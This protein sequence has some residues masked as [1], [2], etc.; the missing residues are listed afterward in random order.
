MIEDNPDHY[1]LIEDALSQ[2]KETQIIIR[3]EIT[4]QL[5]LY[6]LKNEFFDVCLCDLYL[7]DSTIDDSIK[8]LSSLQSKTPVVALSSLD[9]AEV[10]NELS[11]YTIKNCL[12]KNELTATQ[13]YNIC[14]KAI[15][16]KTN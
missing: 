8:T 11:T 12:S 15:N 14:L 4:M 5:G 2:I 3:R 1:E 10:T 7:P 13:I 6:R 16:E 9:I